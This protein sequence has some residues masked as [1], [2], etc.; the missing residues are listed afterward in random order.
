MGRT[1][2][3]IALTIAVATGVVFAIYPALDLAIARR[4]FDSANAQFALRQV[5]ALHLGRDAAML[6]AWLVAVA[7]GM[8][9]V[10][11]ILFPYRHMLIGGRSA[12]MF[13][14]TLLLGP[15][16]LVNAVLKDHW[17]RPRP[18]EVREFG[19]VHAFVAW[20]DPRGDC[21]KNCAFVSGDVSMA[22]WTLVAAAVSPAPVRALAYGVALAFAAA[23]ALQ[24]IVV[25]AHFLTD[26]V[27]SGVFTYLV[28]WLVYFL[29]YRWPATRMTDATIE[30]SLAQAG[31]VIRIFLAAVAARIR[32]AIFSAPGRG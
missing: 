11:K 28:I 31:F 23:V 27:F 10:L 24:R 6:L 2:I 9:L 18:I 3:A 14:A 7:A 26:A 29:I 15:G 32:R 1:G 17:G 5:I 21:P 4:F 8:V 16:L 19:G 25:G 13:I 12:V 20:W 30:R 22:S